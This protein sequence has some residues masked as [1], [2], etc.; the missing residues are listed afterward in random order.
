[1]ATATALAVPAAVER[2]SFLVAE[3]TGLSLVVTDGRHPNFFTFRAAD[4]A[5]FYV[6]ALLHILQLLSH[7]ASSN[8]MCSNSWLWDAAMNTLDALRFGLIRYDG[9][10]GGLCCM[11]G[12]AHGAQCGA[13]RLHGGGG[14]RDERSVHKPHSRF[15]PP[16]PMPP[17]LAAAGFEASV[18]ADSRKLGKPAREIV[19]KLFK[20]A[21]TRA[22]EELAV[23]RAFDLARVSRS[24]AQRGMGRQPSSLSASFGDARR[25]SVTVEGDRGEHRFDFQ[26]SSGCVKLY[27]T[28]A[29][30]FSLPP[31]DFRILRRRLQG[32]RPVVDDADLR[33]AL[34]HAMHMQPPRLLLRV[35]DTSGA[36]Q[37]QTR[38]EA[39]SAASSGEPCAASP[40]ASPA[41]SPVR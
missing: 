24:Q 25:V 18:W 32:W 3:R 7:G 9:C 38:D 20:A 21:A 8:P 11:V 35:E 37:R 12:N 27:R 19:R 28:T 15:Q 36:A 30:A 2:R 5:Y 22:Q 14:R 1:M 41:V 26:L 40:A 31:R 34:Q 13:L 17:A 16:D 6:G 23:K 4:G 39:S 33:A 10:R 29:A